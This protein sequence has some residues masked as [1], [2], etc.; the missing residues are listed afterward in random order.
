MDATAQ[1]Q[2]IRA[3]VQE[4]L[5]TTFSTVTFNFGDNRTD[6]DALL[7]TGSPI[8]LVDWL[9]RS[10]KLLN[11]VNQV[12]WPLSLTV[13]AKLNAD[14]YGAL[15]DGVVSSLTDSLKQTRI[16]LQ[17]Y[18]DPAHPVSTGHSITAIDL[19]DDDI[20]PDDVIRAVAVTADLSYYE[21]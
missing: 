13:V 17:D 11:G 18:T 14:P 19:Y 8:V 9:K 4:W 6:L 2:W 10:R 21:H 12:T 7:K 5:T 20:S 3:S 1:R 16:P 15:V